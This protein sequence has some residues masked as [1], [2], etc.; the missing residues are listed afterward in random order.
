MVPV[1]IIVLVQA[2]I[3][4]L[5]IRQFGF[6]LLAVVIAVLAVLHLCPWYTTYETAEPFIL[7]QPWWLSLW[8]GLSIVLL[9]L[10]YV[11]M[12]WVKDKEGTEDLPAIWE[13]VR[14]RQQEQEED[15]RV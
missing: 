2:G 14:A 1:I 10:L 3:L 8:M 15:N 12:F 11:R 7:G 6:N 5:T 4:W 13:K 9:I